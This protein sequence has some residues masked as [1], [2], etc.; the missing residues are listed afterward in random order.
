M[1]SSMRARCQSENTQCRFF[2]TKPS[3]VWSRSAHR[4]RRAG[5]SCRS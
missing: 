3:G 4:S 1:T 5:R 2:V